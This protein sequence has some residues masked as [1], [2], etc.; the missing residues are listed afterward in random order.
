MALGMFIFERK[1]A[2]PDSVQNSL[3]E[4]FS[5]HNGLDNRPTYQHTGTGE[6]TKTITGTLYPAFTGGELSLFLLEKMMRSGEDFILL[7]GQGMIL[8][9]FIITSLSNNQTFFMGNGK[10]K[11]IEF[12]ITLKRTDNN[13][14]TLDATTDSIFSG[15]VAP[16]LGLF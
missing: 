10:A 11:K 13:K 9:R 16:I 8:G 3:S 4:R 5:T 1:T 2:L 6:D 12:T 15:S 14:T 7:N